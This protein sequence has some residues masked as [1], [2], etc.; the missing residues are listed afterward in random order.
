MVFRNIHAKKT[1]KIYDA[2][3]LL[4]P[5]TIQI[6]FYHYQ[7]IIPAMTPANVETFCTYWTLIPEKSKHNGA[8]Q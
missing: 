7:I 3:S 4:I 5:N 6:Q 1:R 2:F 8:S